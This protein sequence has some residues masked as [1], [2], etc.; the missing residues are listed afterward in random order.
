MVFVLLVTRFTAII[1]GILL[2]APVPFLWRHPGGRGTVTATLYATVA[3]STTATATLL[4]L[5]FG[6]VGFIRLCGFT[7]LFGVA[8]IIKSTLNLLGIVY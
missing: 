3:A 2:T 8:F 7:V 1:A 5:S 4:W 6:P